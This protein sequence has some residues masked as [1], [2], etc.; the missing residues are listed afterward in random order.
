[1]INKIFKHF[2]LVKILLL[3]ILFIGLAIILYINVFA[4]YEESDEPTCGEANQYYQVS[5][6]PLLYLSK[7]KLEGLWLPAE[8]S[9][10][11]SKGIELEDPTATVSEWIFEKKLVLSYLLVNKEALTKLKNDL[12]LTEKQIEE[13]ITLVKEE[14][15]KVF[16]LYKKS[17]A[18][19]KDTSL[20]LEERKKAIEDMKYNKR[21]VEIIKESVQKVKEIFKDQEKYAQFTK[22]I[23]EEWLEESIKHTK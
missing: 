18:I 3:I 21:I 23:E 20:S 4:N 8:P 10:Y 17:Q 9:V 7:D 5:D 15:E 2:F 22:W 16:F 13:I 12:G 14:T 19:A 1:M 6:N 11:E